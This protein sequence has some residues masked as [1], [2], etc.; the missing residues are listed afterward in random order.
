MPEVDMSR[1]VALGASYGGYMINWLNGHDLGRRFKALVCHDGILSL[2]GQ[3][4]TDELY[5]VFTVSHH[6]VSFWFV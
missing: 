3:L 5:F 1:A 2:A 4:A 6:L